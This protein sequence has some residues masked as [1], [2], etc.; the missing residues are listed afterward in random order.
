MEADGGRES[1]RMSDMGEGGSCELDAGGSHL[2]C[3]GAGSPGEVT[4]ERERVDGPSIC[5]AA[6]GA[7]R[8]HFDDSAGRGRISCDPYGARENFE[9]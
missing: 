9:L 5:R 4:G 8:R 3:G 2:L 6:G 7:A 1:G